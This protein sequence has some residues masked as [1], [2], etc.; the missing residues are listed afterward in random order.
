MSFWLILLITAH[1]MQAYFWLWVYNH[2]PTETGNDTSNL[3]MPGVSVVIAVKNEATNLTQ[4]LPSILSQAYANFEVIII[5]D[6]S[7]DNSASIIRGLMVEYPHLILLTAKGKHGKKNALSLGIKYAKNPWILCTD[8][9]CKSNSNQW[10]KSIMAQHDHAD[11]ILGYGPYEPTSTLLNAFINYETWYIA[12]Q[13]MSAALHNRAYMGVGRNL[14][15]RKNIWESIGGYTSHQHLR[16][17]D[18]DLF[19][20]SAWKKRVVIETDPRSWSVSNAADSFSKLW[21]QKRR[22]LSTATSY[23]RKNQFLLSLNFLSAFLVSCLTGFLCFWGFYYVLIPLFCRFIYQYLVSRSWMRLLGALR[24]WLG[25]P[26]FDFAL[27]IYYS[28]Q[29]AI[30]WR[31]KKDW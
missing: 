22:H 12:I 10:I 17:G 21:E 5:D 20:S 14:C 25:V 27:V 19:V 3:S 16:S 15:F 7:I 28:A 23:S 9:D 1:L 11:I 8:A 2:L 29:G 6:H 18:D 24:L 31:K 30:M 4:H 13:Y 26:F